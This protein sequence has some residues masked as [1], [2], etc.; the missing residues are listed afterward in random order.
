M[1]T[2]TAAWLYGLLNLVIVFVMIFGLLGTTQLKAVQA[3]PVLDTEPA[4]FDPAGIPSD[5][6]LHHP[7]TLPDST[8]RPDG[9]ACQIRGWKPGAWY[10]RAK[11]SLELY[12]TEVPDPKSQAIYFHVPNPL[13]K[14][15]SEDELLGQISLPQEP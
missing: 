10:P 4:D 14:D 8:V 6:V 5:D 9:M 15:L 13:A 3:S 2:K 7:N 12:L 11:P 1:R